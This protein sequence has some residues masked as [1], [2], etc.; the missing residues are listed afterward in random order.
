MNLPLPRRVFLMT[1][2]ASGTVLATRA[3]AQAPLDEKDALAVALGYVADAKRV[4]VKKY[5]QIRSRP[6][7]R[8][9]R[10][11]PRQGH[12]QGRRLPV[13]RRQAGSRPGLVQRLGE[14]GVNTLAGRKV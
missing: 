10:A 5:P 13:V 4:D 2:A 14:E 3:K 9:L 12:R 7:L 11:L 6:G 1:L 8:Q